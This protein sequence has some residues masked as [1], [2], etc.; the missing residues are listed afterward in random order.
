MTP[1]T[2][3]IAT[4][5]IAVA[6]AAFA[7]YRGGQPLTLEGAQ[8]VYAQ[9]QSLA[10]ELNE[11]ATVAV[12]ASQQLKESGKLT[13]DE[14]FQRAV[15]HVETWFDQVVEVELDPLIIANVVEGAY[16]LYKRNTGKA[17]TKDGDLLDKWPSEEPK[18]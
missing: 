10:T 13:N 5:I 17:G 11:V 6:I 12:A 14:A 8:A 3:A 4:A 16:N 15:E 18:P 1:E 9:S 7:Y 2:I